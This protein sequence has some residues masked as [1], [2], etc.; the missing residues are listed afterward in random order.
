Y[1]P[2]IS[3]NYTRSNPFSFMIEYRNS[4][5]GY[6]YGE[7]QYAYKYIDPYYDINKTLKARGGTIRTNLNS[8]YLSMPGNYYLLDEYYVHGSW[9][10]LFYVS[11]IIDKHRV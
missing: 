10:G 1:N 3:T 4:D 6:P 2:K 9:R 11:T 8:S 7:S 5:D